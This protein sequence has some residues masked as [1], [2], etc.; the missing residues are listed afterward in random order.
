MT[1]KQGYFFELLKKEE[2]R[3]ENGLNLIASENYPSQDVLSMVGSIFSAKYAEGLVGRRFYSGCA[4]VDLV[5]AEVISLAKSVFGAEHANVQPH[6]GSQANQ[7]VF[8][9]LLNPGDA[10]LA[11][12]FDAGGHLT[13]GHKLNYSG[14][15]YNFSFYS[16]CPNTET[17]DYNLLEAQAK[18]IQPKMIIAGGSAYPRLIDFERI[19]TI[20]KAVGALFMVDMA[21]FAGMVAAKLIPSPVF[22]AD[23]VTFTTHK[24]LRGPRG[25]MILCKSIF[26]KLIDQAVMPG[27]QGGPAMNNIAAKGVVLTESLT[28]EYISYQQQVLSNA[29]TLA[30]SLKNGGCRLVSGGTDTHLMLLDVNSCFTLNLEDRTGLFLEKLFES[31]G[32]YSNKNLIPFD[33][34]GPLVTSGVRFGVPAVTSQGA[35]AGDM[36]MIASIIIESIKHPYNLKR[37]QKLAEEVCHLRKSFRG[38]KS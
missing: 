35:T 21:H 14:K 17:I 12:S 1:N 23:V 6:S 27:V 3:I 2:A 38:L 25:G 22:Y 32:I 20:A 13:H 10:V 37:H 31:I 33:K 29:K 28:T 26:A 24:T 8:Q 16:V 34:K 15:N 9:A 4:I 11:M 5:E 36:E 30:S 18:Q 19:S 7:A